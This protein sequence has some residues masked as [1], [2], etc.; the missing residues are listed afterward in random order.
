MKS[1]KPLIENDR[2][3]ESVLL[4]IGPEGGWTVAEED[5]ALE[6]GVTLFSLVPNVLRAET[7]SLCALAVA[8]VGF[9]D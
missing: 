4:I 9:L 2:K 7:A 8:R 1:V 3:A 6:Q 5:F